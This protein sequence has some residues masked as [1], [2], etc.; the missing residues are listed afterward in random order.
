MAGELLAKYKSASIVR[1]GNP[2]GEDYSGQI[3]CF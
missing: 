1:L 3:L 2:E